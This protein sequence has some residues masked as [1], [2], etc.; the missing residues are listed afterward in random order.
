MQ[1]AT[2]NIDPALPAGW[3]RVDE[4]SYYKFVKRDGE[5]RENL[6]GEPYL[7]DVVVLVTPALAGVVKGPG[8]R[9][10]WQVRDPDAAGRRLASVLEIYLEA[11][12]DVDL[13]AVLEEAAK[14]TTRQ[15][16]LATDGGDRR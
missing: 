2:S 9:Q 14:R 10:S 4:A 12:R 6:S 7:Q 3:E 15:A 5:Q 1:S 11:D 16:R 13:D 8:A